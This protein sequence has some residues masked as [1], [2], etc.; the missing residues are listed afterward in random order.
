[1]HQRLLVAVIDYE[2]DAEIH[3]VGAAS[4]QKCKVHLNL[5]LS[6]T[7][8]VICAVRLNDVHADHQT[9][10][11][12]W[13]FCEEAERLRVGDSGPLRRPAQQPTYTQNTD[14]LREGRN[15]DAGCVGRDRPKADV[16][17]VSFCDDCSP[18][19]AVAWRP[20]ASAG[21]ETWRRT[22]HRWQ[23]LSSR[24]TCRTKPA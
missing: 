24:S 14:P 11:F 16:F 8:Q 6:Q 18:R 23:P 19:R 21:L 2:G 4:R 13:Q 9:S 17:W 3:L 15:P 20:R 1:M 12:L 5:G 10:F 22:W 7:C